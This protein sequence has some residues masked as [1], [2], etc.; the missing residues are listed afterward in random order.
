VRHEFRER[1]LP[2]LCV[3]ALT[4]VTPA[5]VELALGRDP[6]QLTARMHVLAVGFTA[7][8]AAVAAV[9]LSIAG[10]RRRDARAVLTATAFAIMAGLLALHGLATPGIFVGVNGVIAVTGGLTLPAGGLILLLSTLAPPRLLRR[11]GPLLALEAAMIAGLLAL[12]ASALAF[13]DIVPQVPVP[14]SFSALSLLVFGLMIYGLLVLRSLRTFLLTR[15][16]ADLG[17]VVGLAWLVTALVAALTMTYA[18]LGWWLGHELELDGILVVG[19]IVALD[20]ARSTQSR[21]PVGD[22]KAT[23]LVGAEEIFL[24]SHV[25][26]LTRRLAEKDEYTERHARRVALLAVQVGELLGLKTGRLRAL[27]IGGLVHD[28]G[29]LAFP[30]AILKKP[31]PLDDREFEAI[32]RHPDSGSRLLQELGG[33]SE[34]VRRLVRDH[35]ERLDGNGYPRGLTESELD[36]E[37]RILTACDVYDALISPRVY[38][39]AWTHEE[40]VALLRRETGTAFDPRCVAALEQVLIRESASAGPSGSEPTT[41]S[42]SVRRAP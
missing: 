13:P 25:R 27:A 38:R 17:V 22:L 1:L 23:E 16:L 40:A 8:A 3:G 36:L 4:A 30:D 18:Q 2:L 31:G 10:A 6:V 41:S 11:V 24:G 19:T 29:K 20:L 37:T 5:A 21:S 35:H 33:F 42:L 39:P 34:A 12:G 15:R 7:L 26:A 14:N 9:A 32:R 28:I